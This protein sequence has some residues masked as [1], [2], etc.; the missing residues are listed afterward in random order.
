MKVIYVLNIAHIIIT[1][2]K[3]DNSLILVLV[4]HVHI[5][6]NHRKYDACNG[7]FK[8]IY[9]FSKIY[10]CVC[11]CVCVYLCWLYEIGFLCLALA[12]LGLTP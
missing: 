2:K 4:S 12:V 6:P 11:V 9:I 3:Y 8:E 7:V 1:Y 5:I 10:M